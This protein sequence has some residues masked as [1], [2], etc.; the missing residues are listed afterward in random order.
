[1]KYGLYG[2]IVGC[3]LVAGVL[4]LWA[5]QWKLGILA[6]LFGMMNGLIFFWRE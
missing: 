1:M 3:F 5:C 4:D 2:I 6:L